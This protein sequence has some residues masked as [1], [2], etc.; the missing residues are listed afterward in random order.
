MIKDKISSNQKLCIVVGDIVV[1][2]ETR[3][4]CIVDRW[5]SPSHGIFFF[6]KNYFFTYTNKNDEMYEINEQ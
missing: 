4:H 5:F 6:K 1:C 2:F 3:G